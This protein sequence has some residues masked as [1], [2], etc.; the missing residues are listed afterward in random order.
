MEN[1]ANKRM[2]LIFDKKLYFYR[3]CNDQQNQCNQ[4]FA[5]NRIA[6][7]GAHILKKCNLKIPMFL[8][9]KW[10]NEIK[11][12]NTIVISDYAYYPGLEKVILRKNPNCRI[13]FYY[14][15]SMDSTKEKYLDI[16]SIKTIFKNEVYTYNYSDACEYNMNF[17]MTMYK[18][19][20]KSQ[21]TGVQTDFI[22][23]G[24]DK[25]RGDDIANFYNTIKDKY[26]SNIRI[27][28]HTGEL[29][30]KV[31]VDY[32]IYLNDVINSK[33]ILDI[34]QYPSESVT[35]RIMEALFFDKK[36][37][38]NN[39]KIVDLEIYDLLKNNILF[40][41]YATIN[42]IQIDNFMKKDIKK[43]SLKDKEKYNFENWL[44]SI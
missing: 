35:L 26:T 21:K 32:E 34:V 44:E 20:P 28:N 11:Q 42:L 43:I 31:F 3:Y 7:L 14:M 23:L 15:N 8:L 29:N 36:L 4:V 39:T 18:L 1:K 10:K 24:R 5:T 2:F 41:D 27:L 37:I 25:C 16:E 40:V 19:M 6:F 38:T 12:Y 17:K 13:C 9:G 33:V 30:C 22:Y